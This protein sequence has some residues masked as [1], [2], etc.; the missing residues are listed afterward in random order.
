MERSRRFNYTM[1]AR[2]F[3]VYQPSLYKFFIVM[4]QN[5]YIEPGISPVPTLLAHSCSL[6]NEGQDFSCIPTLFRQILHCDE[7]KPIYRARYLTC[8]NSP[9]AF[10]FFKQ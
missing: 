10:L 8:T 1:R 9:C 5:L 3:P 7:S 4:N 2:I 6:N